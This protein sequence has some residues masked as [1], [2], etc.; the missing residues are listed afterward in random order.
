M[1]FPFRCCRRCLAR[2]EWA[3]RWAGLGPQGGR[4]FG[5][6]F[7]VVVAVVVVVVASVRRRGSA[8]TVAFFFDVA[9]SCNVVVVDVVVEV[10]VVVDDDDDDGTSRFVKCPASDD[11][12]WIE[13]PSFASHAPLERLLSFVTGFFLPGFSD[14]YRLVPGFT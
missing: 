8:P 5:S 13:P 10:V 3:G 2:A 7:L 9:L 11:Q 14:L 1:W 4:P 6:S 12:K